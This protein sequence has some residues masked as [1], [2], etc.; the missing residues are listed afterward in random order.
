[1]G[2]LSENGGVLLNGV[3]IGL[4]LF[5]MAVGLTVVFGLL[6]VL[7]LAHG[8]FFLSGAYIG[9]QVAGEA[10]ATWGSFT[11]ALLVAVGVGA[12]IGVALM[13]LT[14]PLAR[15]GHLDQALLTLGLSLVVTELL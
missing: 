1:M 14:R 7:N 13:L 11:L 3:A 9:Y 6:D 12:V 8:A 2:W 4:L 5:M 10:T 15:R